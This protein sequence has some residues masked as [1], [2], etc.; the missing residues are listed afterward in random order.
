MRKKP[1]LKKTSRPSTGI[2]KRVR[3]SVCGKITAARLTGTRN[4]K[5]DGSM[6]FPRRHEVNGA[7]CSGNIESAE[8]INDPNKK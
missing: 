7:P 5:G 4:E 2:R 3:C 6:W 1:L 8:I